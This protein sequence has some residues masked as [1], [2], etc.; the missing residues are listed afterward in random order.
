M[1]VFITSTSTATRHAAYAIEKT[2]PTTIVATGTGVAALCGV[3]PWGPDSATDP[4]YTPTSVSDRTATF[5]PYGMDHTGSAYLSTI[6]K[7]FPTL[8]CVRIL[9][10]AA[11]KA[12]ATLTNAVPTNLITLTAKY[13]GVAGNSL[14]AT[15]SA[16]SDGDANHFNLKVSVTG[17]SGTTEDFLQN[18]NYSGTGSDSA[19]DFSKCFLLG[20]ITRLANGR[21]TNGTYTFSTGAD[22]TINSARYL[23][24]AGTGDAG[25]AKLEGDKTV[26][27]VFCDD[28]GNTDRAAVNAG[29]VAHA[30]LM[31]DRRAYINGNSGLSA[32]AVK[33][34]RA[35]Y[36][37]DRCNYIGPWVYIR[38]DIDGTLRLAPPA[39]FAA[40][41]DTQLSP[42]TSLAWKNSEVQA[43]LTGIADLETDYGAAAGDLSNNGIV[44]IN[45]EAS[46]GFTFESDNT[47]A[48]LANPSLR[49]GKRRKMVD[50][51]GIS[52]VDSTRGSV[53]S[54]NVDV[55]RE[56]LRIALDN[57]MSN[58]KT[59][60]KKDPNHLP[61]V[62]DY[63]IPPDAAANTL[64]SIAAGDYYLP[65]EVQLSSDMER[66]F[67]TIRASENAITVSENS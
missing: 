64:S 38:D 51:I 22:G 34:D 26:R 2:P 4:I 46:G 61:H 19:P 16:A 40:A 29:L 3:F 67:L 5:A 48:T 12:V 10:S 59:N 62:V 28:P 30:I 27:A 44:V 43:M 1:P 54:P 14:I 41:V 21:P 7:G 58:L 65:L 45:R 37:S 8:K 32:S 57:F 47:T 52:F 25:I 35:N 31:G 11:A 17:A 42:S 49:K 36:S 55:N 6:R 13:K 39:A 23:G 50:F 15:V 9:G 33:T 60:A 24:T 20:A 18:L 53:D 56:D 66:L 63:A